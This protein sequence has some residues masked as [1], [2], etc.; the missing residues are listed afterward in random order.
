MKYSDNPF[1]AIYHFASTYGFMDAPINRE[2]FDYRIGLLDEE[3]KETKDAV[4]SRDPEGIVDGHV[5]LVV[6]ALGN[7]TMFRVR[8]R[9]AFDRVMEA[10]MK[11]VV[12]PRQEGDPVDFSL[13]KPL[14]WK[15]PSHEGNH[16]RLN[17]VL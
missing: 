6:V 16:G 3:L 7:L 4:E 9:E 10:N 1:G 13:A 12:G 8:E 5:D 2:V 17:E 11:K 14:G 15:A